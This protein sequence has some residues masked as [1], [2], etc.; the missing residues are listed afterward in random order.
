M[1]KNAIS[2][3]CAQSYLFLIAQAKRLAFL[4]ILTLIWFLG[5]KKYNFI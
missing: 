5:F 1:A 2:D 3:F 4:D